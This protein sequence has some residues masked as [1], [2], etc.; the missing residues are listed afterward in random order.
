MSEQKITVAENPQRIDPRSLAIAGRGT[1]I[2]KK[3]IHDNMLVSFR[4]G[5]LFNSGLVKGATSDNYV[6]VPIGKVRNFVDPEAI[7]PRKA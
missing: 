2:L 7:I 6:I 4:T 3:G 5:M 1:M